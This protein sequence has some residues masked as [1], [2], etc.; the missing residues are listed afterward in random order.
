MGVRLHPRLLILL[1]LTAGCSPT[2]SLPA[3]YPVKGRVLFEGNPIPEAQ[4]TLHPVGHS[5]AVKPVAY[6][7]AQGNFTLSTYG[8]NDGAP[9]GKYIITVQWRQLIQVGEEKTRAGKN[10]LP[11]HYASEKQSKLSCIIQEC[12]NEVPVINVKR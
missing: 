7:D 12:E 6:T 2:S 4:V 1:L 9:A 11:A 8:S 3:C 5:I 10:Q